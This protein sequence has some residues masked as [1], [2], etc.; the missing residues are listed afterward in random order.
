MKLLFA[1]G[2]AL[3]SPGLLADSV[4]SPHKVLAT[5]VCQ[6][7]PRTELRVARAKCSDGNCTLELTLRREGKV[8]SQVDAGELV[9][10]PAG[11]SQNGPTGWWFAKEGDPKGDGGKTNLSLTKGKAGAGANGVLLSRTALVKHQGLPATSYEYY[12]CQKDKLVRA[13]WGNDDG[14]DAMATVF[15][16]DLNGDGVDDITVRDGSFHAGDEA[17][18]NYVYVGKETKVWLWSP[19][20]SRYELRK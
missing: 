15:L 17:H 13:W 11:N 2:L 20:A 19:K 16:K 12:L 14:Q 4:P 18:A 1:A 6:E 10:V 3:F 8:V 5:H 7:K 9:T